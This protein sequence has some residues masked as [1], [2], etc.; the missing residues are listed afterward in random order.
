[1]KNLTINKIFLGICI[2]SLSNFIQNAACAYPLVVTDNNRQKITF[3][4]KPECVVSL[5]PSVTEMM[6]KIGAGENLYGITYHSTLPPEVSKKQIIGG[7]FSPSIQHIKQINPDLIISAPFHRQFKEQLK[8]YTILE[9]DTSSIEDIYKNISLLGDIFDKQKIAKQTIHTIKNDLMLI[10]KRVNKISLSKKKRVVRL[11]G[12][13]EVMTPGDDSF[14]NDYIR[15]AGAIAP[16]FNKNGNVITLSKEEWI[17]FNPEIIYGC[18]GD[19][20]VEQTLLKQPGWKDVDAVRNGKIIYFPC[21]LTCRASVNAGYFVSWLASEI[22]TEEFLNSETLIRKEKVLNSKNINIDLDYISKAYISYSYIYD[23]L[24][25]TLIIEFPKTMTLVS[26]LEGQRDSITSI[27]NHYIPPQI[28][29]LSHRLGHDKLRD[30]VYHVIQKSYNNSSFLF[31]GADMDNLSIQKQTFRDI[32]VYA[33]VTAGVKSNAV[34][35]SSDEGAFYEPGTINIIIMT[36]MR[37]SPK[38]M[39]RA[40]ISVTEAKSAAMNDLDIRS[41]ANPALYQ[42]TGTGTDNVIVIQGDGQD[43]NS[44]GG[45]TKMGELI[46]KAVYDGILEAVYKQNGITMK[47][48]IFQKL[49]ERHISIFDIANGDKKRAGS[50]ETLLLDSRY[51]SFIEASFAISDDYEKGVTKDVS[52]FNLW[53]KEIAKEIGNKKIDNLNSFID[54][55]EIPHIV[56]MAFNALING[57]ENDRK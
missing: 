38:A 49:R 16:Q 42:A 53:C 15:A 43:I 46:A 33:L 26:T 45:H 48:N 23:F 37:L 30:H 21:D 52:L 17:K 11:M 51:A 35:M 2:L 56:A 22:Y 1:M 18:G 50:L 32:V 54:S 19:R 36:N 28:W 12:R 4:K 8:G 57:I 6:F 3:I 39:T 9:I 47:R 13:K 25:K 41:T 14:Q 29:S 55:D 31:T 24:N 7:F 10:N 34:R 44:T 20:I 5:V 27:G 40:I